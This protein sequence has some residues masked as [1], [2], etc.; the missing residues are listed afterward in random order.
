MATVAAGEL[1]WPSCPWFRWWEFSGWEFADPLRVSRAQQLVRDILCPLR[2]SVGIID[3][4]AGGWYY[5]RNGYP[6]DGGHATGAFVD[7]VP[8]DARLRDAY[9]WIRDSVNYGELILESDHVHV[10]LPGFGGD[11]QA[12]IELPD[13]SFQKDPDA[14]VALSLFYAAPDPWAALAL[15]GAAVVALAQ[16]RR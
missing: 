4:S 12:L 13:G 10:S 9:E 8:R 2:E 16:R 14:P 1:I 6:R 7:F 11:R 3:V 15:A 5:S